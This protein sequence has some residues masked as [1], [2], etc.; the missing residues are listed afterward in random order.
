MAIS[1]DPAHAWIRGSWAGQEHD[2]RVPMVDRGGRAMSW[3]HLGTAE[4]LCRA[5][6]L[7]ALADPSRR[8]HRRRRR[9]PRRAAHGAREH[10]RRHLRRRRGATLKARVA[11][12]IAPAASLILLDIELG[13]P[14]AIASGALPGATALVV[15]LEA[16]GY[17]DVAKVDES[18]LMA[19]WSPAAARRMGAAACKLLLPFRVDVPDQA[20]RQDAVAARCAAACREAGTVL[21]LEPIVYRRPGEEIAARALRASWSWPAPSGSP[22]PIPG[23]SRCSTPGRPTP[24]A[25]ST[26]RAGRARRGC[27]S[28]AARRGDPA[29]AGGRG[30]P[31]PARAASSSAAPSGRDALVQDPA[32]RERVLA[33][34]ARPAAGAAGRDRPG[35]RD[36]VA[37]AG[38]C[39]GTAGDRP[40]SRHP[41]HLTMPDAIA[42]T[43]ADG[44]GCSGHRRGERHRPR[45][46]RAAR[47]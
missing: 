21:V 3:S 23:C 6:T 37:H 26:R 43:P 2:P 45:G 1:D 39:P 11:A 41:G 29:R 27:C 38:G 15:P 16:S 30:V 40:V 44:T 19:G 18:A 28:A 25:R 46:R 10:R 9:P 47:R 36:A 17:G 22:A 14:A 35:A 33:E 8:L 34:R 4:A 31:R 13:A 7:D 24:A 12:A 42:F 32:E 5:R 20:E